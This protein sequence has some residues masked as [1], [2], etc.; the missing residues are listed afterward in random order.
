MRAYLGIDL[1]TTRI[2]AGLFDGQG[3]RLALVARNAPPWA[4]GLPPGWIEFDT[5]AYWEAVCAAVLDLPASVRAEIRGIGLS[6]QAQTFVP[7]DAQGRPLRRAISWLDTRAQVEADAL[8]RLID[9]AQ[10]SRQCGFADV[11]PVLLVAKLGWL[12]AHEPE[13][14]AR[15]SCFLFLRDV[16]VFRL[17]GVLATDRTL[18]MLGGVYDRTTGGHWTEILAHVGLTVDR[19]PTIYGACAPAG[20]T[21]GAGAKAAGLPEN[22][23]IALGCLDQIA[24]A[25]GVGNIWPGAVSVNGGTVLTLFLTRDTPEGDPQGRVLCGEHILPG[26]G[27]VMPYVPAAGAVLDWFHRTFGGDAD[28]ATLQAEAEGV[29]AGA[30]GL[31]C[32][33]HIAGVYSPRPAP[34]VRAVFCGIGTEHTR[35]HFYRAIHEGLAYAVR[36]NLDLLR[37]LGACPGTLPMLGGLAQNPLWLQALADVT[38]LP[39]ALPEEPEASVLAAAMMG[40]VASGDVLDLETTVAAGVRMVRHIH[41]RAALAELYDDR[42]V[43]YRTWLT[44]AEH[45]PAGQGVGTLR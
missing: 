24:A 41:P 5:E 32:V 23:P 29:P 44:S 37:T 20:C 12:R 17:A 35:G 27:F 3:K 25:V 22:V 36:E 40:M 30:D 6:S 28:R 2:K 9:P 45:S 10:F 4:Q 26:R 11:L 42:F 31:L 19:L 18:A 14:F 13:V 39:V 21:T 43:R 34:Q 16:V 15:A 38:R 33:P 1:G 8:R 7:V